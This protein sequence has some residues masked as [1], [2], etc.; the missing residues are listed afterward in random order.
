MAESE[1]NIVQ[2]ARQGDHP[3]FSKL[4][5]RYRR[6]ILS[7]LY[8]MTG[9]RDLTEDLL[10]ET[11]SR[12][13]MLLPNLREESKFPAWLF[14]IAR[15]VAR[16]KGRREL[17]D[18]DRVDLEA[19]GVDAFSDTRPDPETDAINRQLYQA[20]SKGFAML[21]EDRRAALALRVLGEK[22]YEEIAEI[23]GWSLARVKIE[24]HRA[25]V[26]MRKIMEPFLKK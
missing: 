25:R 11:A 8:G 22:R 23:T 18:V 15:N 2:R 5:Q 1:A 26:E 4:F 7:F 16:E 6:P 14:G 9:R 24:I 3:A 17:R 10:Q 20:I 21:D 13:F 12:A 19:C